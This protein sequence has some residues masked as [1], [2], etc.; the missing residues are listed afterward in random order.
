[1]KGGWFWILALGG[2]AV[3]LLTKQKATEPKVTLEPGTVTN[4]S[5]QQQGWGYWPPRGRYT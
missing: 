1:M 3:Y 5:G 2:V 4:P